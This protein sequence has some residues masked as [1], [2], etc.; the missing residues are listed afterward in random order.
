VELGGD[1]V[2]V[3]ARGAAGI[4]VATH[5]LHGIRGVW[6]ARVLASSRKTESKRLLRFLRQFP[7]YAAKERRTARRCLVEALLLEDGITTTPTAATPSLM[8]SELRAESARILLSRPAASWLKVSRSRCVANLMLRGAWDTS[9]D[10][11]RQR[12]IG[13]STNLLIRDLKRYVWMRSGNRGHHSAR[14]QN[15]HDKEETKPSSSLHGGSRSAK[16]PYPALQ[17]V[18]FPETWS[19]QCFATAV[20]MLCFP[21][22]SPSNTVVLLEY[23]TRSL[24]YASVEKRL[25][26]ARY[27][28]PFGRQLQLERRGMAQ[29][30]LEALLRHKTPLDEGTAVRLGVAACDLG[31]SFSVVK[32]FVLQFTPSSP[33][34]EIAT[35][36]RDYLLNVTRL[37]THI[38]TREVQ[39]GSMSAFGPTYRVP[40][41]SSTLALWLLASAPSSLLTTSNSAAA[42]AATDLGD[43]KSLVEA[44]LMFQREDTTCRNDD[45]SPGTLQRR[46][47]LI[48]A[49][50]S[51]ARESESEPPKTQAKRQSGVN[52]EYL[53]RTAHLASTVVNLSRDAPMRGM[54]HAIQECGNPLLNCDRLLAAEA[55]A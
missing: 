9:P 40:T 39:P 14:K 4:P 2:N 48:S 24:E 53:V 3:D 18:S 6:F 29:N 38:N 41:R 42:A 49:L 32:T 1:G 21:S 17:T 11:H 44:Y 47:R 19:F 46:W 34:S 25:D 27:G 35:N 10:Q 28:A 36:R 15:A 50:T 54:L 51:S 16:T 31:V 23:V 12:A 30:A 52:V 45:L 7:K 43:K 20:N 26:A 37:F 5:M 8:S 55:L 33:E 22:T 13:V